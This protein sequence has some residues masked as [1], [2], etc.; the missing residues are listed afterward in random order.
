MLRIGRAVVVAVSL[1]RFRASARRSTATGE[2]ALLL[3]G[4][5]ENAATDVGTSV[6][7]QRV[8]A[9]KPRTTIVPLTQRPPR[10]A[11]LCR[12]L[13]RGAG[14]LGGFASASCA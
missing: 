12:A 14:T 6:R 10:S 13:A 11:H 3:R 5:D 2:R 7:L 1:N 8:D 4:A 9:P